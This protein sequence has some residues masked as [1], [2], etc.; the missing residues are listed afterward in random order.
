MDITTERVHINVE[1]QTMGGY[2]VRP[3]D[4]TP[5]PAVIVYMES[6]GVNSH[7]QEVAQR[8][9]QEGYV[10]L[11]PDFFHRTGPGVEYGYDEQ[12]MNDGIKL[13]SQL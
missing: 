11:A 13:L 2:L 7:I 5:R 3:A 1:N 4:S 12:G 8:V 6:F 9:A 10:A